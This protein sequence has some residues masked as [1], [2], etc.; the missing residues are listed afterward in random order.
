MKNSNSETAGSEFLELSDCNQTQLIILTGA[1]NTPLL[2]RV[3][4]AKNG[5]VFI[6]LFPKLNQIIYN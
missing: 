4:V 2:S 3:E 5:N 6:F 1:R